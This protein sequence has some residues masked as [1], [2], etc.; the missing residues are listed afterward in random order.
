MVYVLN[1]VEGREFMQMFYLYKIAL[2]LRS[3]KSACYSACPEVFLGERNNVFMVL[4]GLSSFPRFDFRA[5]QVQN[6]KMKV[7]SNSV[8]GLG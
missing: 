6:I 1:I 7:G 5:V 8:A 2:Q 4:R 3:S